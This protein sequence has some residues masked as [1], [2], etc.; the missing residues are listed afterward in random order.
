MPEKTLQAVEAGPATGVKDTITPN[1]ESAHE[2]MRALK[3][4]GIDYDDVV[5]VLEREG[6]AKFSASW[7]ELLTTVQTA[8]ESH[9]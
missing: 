7:Q 9:G 2:T 1:L 4:A 5:H 6:V 3:A 8:L